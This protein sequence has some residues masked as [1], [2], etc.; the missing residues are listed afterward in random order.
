[1]KGQFKKH[2]KINF[3]SL[4]LMSI[5]FIS[6]S[7]AW[8]AYSGIIGVSTDIDINSW[9]IELSK[10]GEPVSNKMVI[11]LTDLYPGMQPM[12]ERIVIKNKGDSHAQISYSVIS[13]RI[14]D[15]DSYKPEDM[16]ITSEYVQDL[17][18]YGY[19]FS[20]NMEL[21]KRYVLSG[22]EDSVFEISISWPLDSG[23]DEADSIWGRK[24]YEFI[25]SEEDKRNIDSDYQIKPSIQ[26]EISVIAEQFIEDE[27]TPDVRYNLGDEILIDVIN[28]TRCDTLSETCIK[29][30][31]IDVNNLI[32]NETVTL[33]PTPYNNYNLSNF[34][35]YEEAINW[36]V[37]TRSLTLD[38][39][40]KVISNDINNSLI[41]SPNLSDRI[42]GNYKN[43]IRLE[44]ILTD[45]KEK[46]GYFTFSNER[47]NYLNSVNCFWTN[48]EYNESLGYAIVKEDEL[49]SIIYGKP[50]E[51]ECH[52]IPVIEVDKNIL[53]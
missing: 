33:L 30:N 28:N 37:R 52:V 36:N 3:M 22:G 26:V 31:V 11:S 49:R 14:L 12:N 41:K 7:L 6:V 45:V 21:S 19:P 46:E 4:F 48:T 20:I 1:M 13:A 50:K 15:E 40:L 9:Y 23:N 17:L 10:D 24:A 16:D 51:E 42:I 34:F 5:S 29:T 18:S 27:T 38:D 35:N 32:S 8:F 43:E 2:L 25:K 39:I 53:E 44:N 47:F